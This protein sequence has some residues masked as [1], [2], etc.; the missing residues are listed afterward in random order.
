MLYH[1]ACVRLLVANH[2]PAFHRPKHGGGRL[3]S[4]CQQLLIP[5]TAAVAIGG[6]RSVAELHPANDRIK[7]EK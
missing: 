2:A 6:A 4:P 5:A 3:A 1:S 7:S